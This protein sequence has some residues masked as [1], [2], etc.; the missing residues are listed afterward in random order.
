MHKIKN[1]L[2]E[3]VI[4]VAGVLIALAIDQWNSDRLERA[5]EQAAIAQLLED[6]RLDISAF[7]FRLDRVTQKEESLLRVRQDLASQETEDPANFLQDVIF[8]ADFGW[9]QG[10]ATRA[11][12]N[13]L[14]G[15]G[16][17]GIIRDPEVRFR[18]SRYYEYIAAEEPRMDERET[19]SPGL[20]YQHVPRQRVEP[21]V[22]FLVEERA[23]E[24]GLSDDALRS[25]VDN[26]MKSSIGRLITAEINLARFIRGMTLDARKQAIKLLKRLEAYQG[27]L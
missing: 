17:L 1:A 2:G 8:G 20:S 18:I 21:T 16:N 6:L 3:L 7:D 27:V 14:L 23:V 19:A 5:E 15:A 24:Q 9:N 10:G 13:D 25:I 4:I 11:T 12:Y 26:V 22:D